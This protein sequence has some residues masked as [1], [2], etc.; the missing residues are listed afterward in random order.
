MSAKKR[1]D[2]S[3]KKRQVLLVEDSI[4]EVYLVRG[5]LEKS[6]VFQVTLAQDGDLAARLIRDRDWDLI[7]TDLNLPG[8]DGYDLIRM[9]KSKSPST[10]VIAMTGYMANHYIDQAY[11]AGADHVLVKPIERDDLME[12]ASAL[13]GAEEET[14]PTPVFVLAVGA[15]PGDIEAGC[16]ATLLAYKQKGMGVLLIPLTAAA[17]T[18]TTS[19]DSQRR[20][21]ELMGARLIITGASVSHADN[22]VE[23]QMLLERIVRELKPV[24]AFVPSLADDNPHRREA[25][26]ISRAAVADVPTVLGYETGSSTGEFAPTRFMDVEPFLGKKLDVLAA[27]RDQGRPDLDPEYTQAMARYWGRQVKFGWAEAFEV[28]REPERDA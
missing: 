7:V 8:I 6:G 22:P 17:G 12:K 9:V 25:H 28:L 1:S 2:G 18:D 20:A 24:I 27:Y 21:A 14:E 19:S 5:F 23:H 10:P 26:R 15:L 3:G 11:R 16:G 4:E 13:V